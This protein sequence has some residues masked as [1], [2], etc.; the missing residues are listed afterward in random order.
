M[1]EDPNIVPKSAILQSVTAEANGFYGVV[2]TVASTFLGGSLLFLEK[3]TPAKSGWSIV[4]ISVGWIS[5]VASIGC[6]ARLRFMNLRSGKLALTDQYDAAKKID[7]HTDL[8]SN[9]SQWLLIAGM[10]ALVIVGILNFNQIGKSGRKEQ[11]SNQNDSRDGLRESLPYGS[12][13]PSAP[14]PATQA[15]QP[16]QSS[17]VSSPPPSDKK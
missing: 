7:S 4:V 9:W 8:L 3:F 2:V 10:F 16:S 13:K 15:P 17:P 1:A 12:L 5:L 11:M 6:I 14:P